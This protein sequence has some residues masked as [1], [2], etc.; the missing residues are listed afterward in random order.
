MKDRG[1]RVLRWH[2]DHILST[3]V[4]RLEAEWTENYLNTEGTV[5]TEWVC[6]GLADT[7]LGIILLVR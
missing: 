1:R 5:I 4:T 7:V 6:S 2:E 3:K